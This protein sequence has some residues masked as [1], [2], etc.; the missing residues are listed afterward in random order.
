MA[1]ITRI[2]WLWKKARRRDL[3]DMSGDHSKRGVMHVLLLTALNPSHDC[4]EED[5]DVDEYY[6]STCATVK[7]VKVYIG[8]TPADEY[9]TKDFFLEWTQFPKL[10]TADMKLSRIERGW[11]SKNC[12]IGNWRDVGKRWTKEMIIC[13][14]GHCPW[15]NCFQM[16][17]LVIQIMKTLK[18]EVEA[19]WNNVPM[20]DDR[21]CIIWSAKYG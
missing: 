4:R 7:V 1:E 19:I 5:T 10:P 15:C 16:N 12:T 9:A 14:Q 20:K 13:R 11:R 6:P 3:L 2:I 8:Q 18:M 21:E 17:A